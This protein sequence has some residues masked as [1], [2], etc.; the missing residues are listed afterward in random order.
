MFA[1][2]VRAVYDTPSNASKNSLVEMDSSTPGFNELTS[3]TT[4]DE[5]SRKIR[6]GLPVGQ[7]T[8]IDTDDVKYVVT[9]T[10]KSRSSIE[11]GT[12]APSGQNA[13]G[14]VKLTCT[15]PFFV[16]NQLHCVHMFAV[17]NSC[18]LRSAT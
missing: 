12:L 15:C 18:Q 4:N 5:F 8:V 3:V 13:T 1:H 10:K 11:H 2:E 6:K 16:H 9:I 14:M 17:F 7:M